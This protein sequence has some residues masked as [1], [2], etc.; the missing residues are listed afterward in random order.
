MKIV[1][2]ALQFLHDGK[3]GGQ[4]GGQGQPRQGNARGQQGGQRGGPPQQQG[5]AEHGGGDFHDED[6]DIPF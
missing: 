4:Q 6:D 5:P 3:G 1:A 2:E